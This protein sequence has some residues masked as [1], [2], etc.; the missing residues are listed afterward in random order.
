VCRVLNS[1][2]ST[3]CSGGE[4]GDIL[5]VNLEIVSCSSQTQRPSNERQLAQV[6][7]NLPHLHPIHPNFMETFLVELLH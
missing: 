3:V 7:G 4:C 1:L 5:C 2:S 6:L